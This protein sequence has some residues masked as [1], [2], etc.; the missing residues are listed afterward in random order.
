MPP[1]RLWTPTSAHP[2]LDIQ[3][4]IVQDARVSKKPM[5]WR[6][7]DDGQGRFQVLDANGVAAVSVDLT[8][9]VAPKEA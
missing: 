4:H 8:R 3:K 5:G 6:P 2:E 1:S 7:A 9:W